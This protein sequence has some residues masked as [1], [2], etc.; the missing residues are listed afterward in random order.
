MTKFRRGDNRVSMKTGPMDDGRWRPARA[1]RCR[2]EI[3]PKELRRMA[4]DR[5]KTNVTARS[6]A[7]ASAALCKFCGQK[8]EVVMRLPGKR[9][10]RL[11][12]ERAAARR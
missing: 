6:E 9:M 1:V 11:C 7:K 12:C 10:A 8:V 5:S 3:T 2:P 4:K